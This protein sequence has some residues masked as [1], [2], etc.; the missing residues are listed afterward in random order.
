MGNRCDN[1]SKGVWSPVKLIDEIQMFQGF[2][3][4]INGLHTSEK[5]DIYHRLQCI[6]FE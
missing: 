1:G 3:K 2:E 5:F 6:S 4:A